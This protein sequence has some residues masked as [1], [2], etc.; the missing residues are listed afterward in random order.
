M[1]KGNHL[2]GKGS[3]DVVQRGINTR[4]TKENAKE[5]GRR[6]GEVRRGLSPVRQAMKNIANEALYNP[7][8]VSGEQKKA[9]AEFFGIS[10][11]QIT[12]AHLAIYK[13]AIE[14]A[15]GNL[16]ALIFLRDMNGEKPAENVSVS[17]TVAQGDFVLEIGG[18]D[19]ADAE[20]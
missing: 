16:Q 15:K 20:T 1:S 11:T 10:P 17:A 6:S 2:G 7:A 14:A 9:I 13:Q 5:M 3:A 4:F 12:M 19:D 8:P 18:E